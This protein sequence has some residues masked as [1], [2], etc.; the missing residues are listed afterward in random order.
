L[1]GEERKALVDSLAKRQL[2]I[3]GNANICPKTIIETSVQELSTLH[4]ML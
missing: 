3:W 1:K 2:D 4:F